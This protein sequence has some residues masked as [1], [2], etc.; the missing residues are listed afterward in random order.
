MQASG[1]AGGASDSSEGRRDL[2]LLSGRSGFSKTARNNLPVPAWVIFLSRCGRTFIVPAATEGEKSTPASLGVSCSQFAARW[3]GERAHRRVL[4]VPSFFADATGV[5]NHR[6][7]FFWWL[8]AFG[9]FR[10]CE[11]FFSFLVLGVFCAG[12]S[13]RE[14]RESDDTCMAPLL[15]HWFAAQCR[16]R[17]CDHQN[18]LLRMDGLVLFFSLGK[19]FNSSPCI[20]FSQVYIHTSAVVLSALVF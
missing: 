12:R 9:L 14:G 4:C 1:S 10:V 11:E 13:L 3:D 8:G 5:L 18:A 17:L 7:H 15:T 2:G 19:V 20:W 6:S 16:P